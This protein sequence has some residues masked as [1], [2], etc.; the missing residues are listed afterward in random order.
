M[1]G[2]GALWLGAIRRFNAALRERTERL[3]RAFAELQRSHREW[4]R[5]LAELK[6]AQGRMLQQA[7]MAS[8]GQ[9]AAGVAH[10]INNPL[11]FVTNNIAVLKREVS[12][13]HDILVLYGRAE[14]TL[15]PTRASCSARSTPWPIG[16]TC[17]SCST[18]STT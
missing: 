7:K 10:E 2:L 4:A 9:T 14:E 5:A 17:R 6:E 15:A 11:A 18:T 13:L 8:L 1:L 16:S 12:G 3:G